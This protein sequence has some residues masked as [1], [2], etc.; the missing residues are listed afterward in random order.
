MP[1]TIE[2][3]EVRVGGF[4]DTLP[5]DLSRGQAAMLYSKLVVF[6]NGLEPKPKPKRAYSWSEDT[7]AAQSER[8][9]KRMKDPKFKAKIMAAIKKAQAARAAQRANGGSV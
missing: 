6:V 4:L 1:L 8:M 2:E 5:L 9:K 7:R 3:I